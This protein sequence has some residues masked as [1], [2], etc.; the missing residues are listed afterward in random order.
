MN[1]GQ[2]VG[3]SGYGVEAGEEVVDIIVEEAIV[4]DTIVG[5]NFSISNE[6]VAPESVVVL[7]A[8]VGVELIIVSD[9]DGDDDNEVVRDTMDI[10]V[11]ETDDEIDSATVGMS[12]FILEACVDAM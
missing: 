11:A 4:G 10:V 2:E 7:K 8:N 6:N 5:N 9:D 1:V 3:L 12:G